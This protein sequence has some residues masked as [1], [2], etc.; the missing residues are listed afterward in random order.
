VNFSDILGRKVF[1]STEENHEH[2][3]RILTDRVKT[4]LMESAQH[5]PYRAGFDRR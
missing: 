2:K 1:E 4:I 3:G 5:M